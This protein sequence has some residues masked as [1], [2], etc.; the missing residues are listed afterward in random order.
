ML[1]NTIIPEIFISFYVSYNSV[2]LI[3]IILLLYHIIVMTIIYN[4][5]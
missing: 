4:I 5:V 2:I 3:D 1:Y